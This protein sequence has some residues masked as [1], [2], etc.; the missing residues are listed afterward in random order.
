MKGIQI[1]VAQHVSIQCGYIAFVRPTTRS[2]DFTAAA[3]A[4]IRILLK[5]K[6]EAI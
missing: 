1:N 2:S 4:V 3:A 6:P 5:S